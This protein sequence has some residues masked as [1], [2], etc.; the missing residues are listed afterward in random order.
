MANVFFISKY[1]LSIFCGIF[2]CIFCF[3]E[4]SS[5]KIESNFVLLFFPFAKNYIGRYVVRLVRA[6]TWLG[7]GVAKWQ[8]YLKHT[9][10]S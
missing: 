9:K 2:V 6:G 7:R 3:S 10:Y 1:S 8:G 5:E 4:P